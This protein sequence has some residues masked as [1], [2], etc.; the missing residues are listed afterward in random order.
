MD[1]LLFVVAINEHSSPPA[2]HEEQHHAIGARNKPPEGRELLR[3]EYRLCAIVARA[4]QVQRSLSQLGG[5]VDC[6]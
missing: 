4:D 3:E 1:A 2:T 6:A 5:D